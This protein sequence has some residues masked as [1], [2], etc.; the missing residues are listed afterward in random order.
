MGV[1]TNDRSVEQKLRFMQTT[2]KACDV[3]SDALNHQ[4]FSL[5]DDEGEWSVIMVISFKIDI[6][7]CNWHCQ[8]L[9]LEGSKKNHLWNEN[10]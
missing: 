1:W 2:F 8:S 6:W 10:V 3:S 7:V 4:I 9:L 5:V